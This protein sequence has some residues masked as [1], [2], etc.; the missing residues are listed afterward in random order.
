M[1]H[2]DRY[3]EY[4]KYRHIQKIVNFLRRRSRTRTLAFGLENLPDQGPYVLFPNHQGKYDGLGVV[5]THDKPLSIIMEK[6]KAEMIV[7]K[8]M[9]PLVKGRPIDLEDPRQQIKTLNGVTK[10]IKEGRIYLI[11]PEGGYDNNE[12]RVQPF[13]TGVFKCV[14]DTKCPVVPVALID[15]FKAMNGNSLKKVT[16]QVHYMKP[17]YY[18]EYK[19]L[20]RTDFANLL[21]ELIQNKIDE[22]LAKR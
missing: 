3:D 2:S 19:D 10:D 22:E 14:Y 9:M 18:E 20:K 4:E 5:C 16:T 15:S 17:I 11:F 13:R 12:N 1:E 8:Q 21:R 6:K 7:A